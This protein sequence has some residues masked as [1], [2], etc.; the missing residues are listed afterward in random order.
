[1]LF[2]SVYKYFFQILVANERSRSGDH[3]LPG[4]QSD[5]GSENIFSRDK[6]KNLKIVFQILS[7]LL[8]IM[9]AGGRQILIRSPS[10]VE[11]LCSSREKYFKATKSTIRLTKSKVGTESCP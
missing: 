3:F 5:S 6:G 7:K 9:T 2:R 1:M 10:E 4:R 11:I 8:L